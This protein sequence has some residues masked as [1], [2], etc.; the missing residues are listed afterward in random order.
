MFWEIF[1]AYFRSKILIAAGLILLIV[2]YIIG[3]LN[4]SFLFFN[5]TT[6]E[7]MS[8][9][10]SIYSFL[11]F[12]LLLKDDEYIDLKYSANFWWVCGA[13]FYYFSSTTIN[14]LRDR[15]TSPY[16]NFLP[17]ILPVSNWILYCCWIYSF[18][19]KGWLEKISKV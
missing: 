16:Y 9:L 17:Y 19:C 14:L 13:F 4:H 12:Y 2:F 1:R 10:F 11:Y 18:I 5:D 15:L 6:N 8:V 7:V 3:V